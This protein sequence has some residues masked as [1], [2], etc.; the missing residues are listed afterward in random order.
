M[1]QRSMLHLVVLM[2]VLS[3]PFQ[4]AAKKKKSVLPE[5]VSASCLIDPSTC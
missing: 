5:H 4:A 1:S 3:L 2:C